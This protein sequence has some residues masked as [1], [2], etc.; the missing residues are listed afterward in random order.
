MK[1]SFTGETCL[2]PAAGT[3]D[4]GGPDGE[5]VGF[6]KRRWLFEGFKDFYCHWT[7]HRDIVLQ[8]LLVMY[9][10]KRNRA[11][12]GPSPSCL[13]QCSSHLLWLLCRGLSEA[14]DGSP[15]LLNFLRKK[16]LSGSS[17]PGKL[18]VCGPR[19]VRC[20]VDAQ[21]SDAL[22]PLC[23]REVGCVQSSWIS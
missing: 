22:S 8:Q 20:D 16:S 6:N 3:C 18:C 4:I 13:V 9:I 5:N 14:E 19:K 21:E 1:L 23:G 2:Q 12:P 10:I 17:S 11:P 15:V 7:G